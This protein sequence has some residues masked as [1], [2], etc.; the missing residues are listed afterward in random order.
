[1]WP[2]HDWKLELPFACRNKSFTVS[3]RVVGNP[4]LT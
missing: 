4:E 2:T 1:L 3:C